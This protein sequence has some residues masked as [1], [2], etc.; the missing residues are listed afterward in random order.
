MR[1]LVS[2]LLLVGVAGCGGVPPELIGAWVGPTTL[3]MGGLSVLLDSQALVTEG[4]GG[5]EVV[6]SGSE[7]GAPA[8]GKVLLT[9]R[10][11]AKVTSSGFEVTNGTC[12]VEGAPLRCDDGS[13]RP[14]LASVSR[15]TAVRSGTSLAVN[16]SGVLTN[17]CPGSTYPP[18]PFTLQS[19]LTKR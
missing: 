4:S 2:L 18:A 3:S 16:T 5:L 7:S 19:N 1:R 12:D 14:P 15:L 6:A 11:G 10:I 8:S 9:C 13:Q 17:P